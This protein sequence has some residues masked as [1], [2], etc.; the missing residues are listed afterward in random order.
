MKVRLSATN[1]WI[2]SGEDPSVYKDLGFVVE[3]Y[4]S[5]SR[6]ETC[7]ANEPVIEL[8]S[9]EE[10]LDLCRRIGGKAVL[11]VLSKPDPDGC[12]IELEIYNDYRE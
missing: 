3:D 6:T 9:M 2:G 11:I 1:P 10:L 5:G 8:W 12:Q 4:R 7:L